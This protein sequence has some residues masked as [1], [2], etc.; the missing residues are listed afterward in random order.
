MLTTIFDEGFNYGSYTSLLADAAAGTV[1][2]GPLT[3]AAA[4]RQPA[5]QPDNALPLNPV[6]ALF[7]FQQD[8][9]EKT[10]KGKKSLKDEGPMLNTPSAA[11]AAAAAAAAGAVA[12]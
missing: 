8:I 12:F 2:A 5:R 10:K 3:T 9:E 6:T 7:M 1:P 4:A 11:A